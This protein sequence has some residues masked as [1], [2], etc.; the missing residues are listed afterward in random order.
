M[1]KILGRGI[2]LLIGWL[3]ASL[4][5]AQG[6]GLPTEYYSVNDGL[7]DRMV[8]DIAESKDGLL[9]LSTPNGLNRFDGYGFV[10]FDNHPD[11]VNQISDANIR[12][13]LPMAGDR[14][15]IVYRS[16]YAL[17]D[18]FDPLTHQRETV[19]LL[20]KTGVEGIPRTIVS[21]RAG[22][23][24]ALSIADQSTN[25][26][27]YQG[28][29][30]FELLFA[31][32]EQ[33]EETSTNIKMLALAD[34]SFLIHDGEKGTRHF[35]GEGYRLQALQTA[36]FIGYKPAATAA[37]TTI[38]HQDCLG[39]V[40]LAFRGQPGMYHYLP[41]ERELLY[42]EDLPR[43]AYYTRLWEDAKGN[44][45]LG[46]AQRAGELYPLKQLTAIRPDGRQYDFSY[47]LLESQ[48]IVSAHSRDFFK[49]LILGIDTGLKI[50]QNRQSRVQTYLAER[51]IGADQRG[52][53]MRGVVG[54]KQGNVYMAREV[55]HWYR[56]RL[57]SNILDTLSMI[58]A[59][60]GQPLQLACGRGLF[61]DKAGCLWGTSCLDGRT[62]RLHRYNPATDTVQTYTYPYTFS[63]LTLGRDGTIWLTAEPP[64]PKGQLIQFDPRTAR[65]SVFRDQ[66][67]HNPLKDASPRFVLESQEGILWVGSEDGLYRIDPQ[68]RTVDSYIAERGKINGLASNVV[69]AIHED[70]QGRLWLGTTNG[71]NIFDPATESFEHYNQ[72]DGLVSNTVCGFV[73]DE[74]GNY[75]VSTFNGLS[76]FDREDETFHNFFRKEGLSHD[77]F[78]RFSYY[79]DHLGNFYFGGVNGMNVF[80]TE[81]LL[82]DDETPQPILTKFSRYNTGLDSTIVQVAGLNDMEEIVMRPKDSYFNFHF[83]IPAYT[84]PRRNQFKT[85]LSGYDKK[86]TYQSSDAS[87]RLNHLPIGSYEL[88]V[89]GADANGNWS[90]ETLRIPIVVEPAYYQTTWFK[91]LILALISFIVYRIFLFRL[92]QRVK[93][94]RIRTKLSS[95][96]HDEVSGLLAGIAMQTDM[97]QT[98]VKDRESLDRIQQMGEV[99]RKAMSKMSDVIWSI[100]SRKDR[101]EELIIRMREHADEMLSPLDVAYELKV[102]DGID[103]KRKIPVT[104]RQNLYFI[105]KEAVNNIAK[106]SRATKVQIQL[107]NDGSEFHM[108][109]A[110]NG[111]AVTEKASADH[112]PQHEHGK[113]DA[114]APPLHRRRKKKTG[115]GLSNLRMRAARIDAEIDIRT[116]GEGYTVAL[117][118]RRFA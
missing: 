77:E 81:D 76:Y 21:N 32:P 105:F 47:L 112:V 109:I 42:A 22:E 74:Q 114:S 59:A 41:K 67:G 4:L 29:G 31:I 66:E 101:V 6:S 52:A 36:D 62:G 94:E 55:D 16:S 98:T 96:L 9:W 35:S 99:S 89:K 13:L 24:F 57:D 45:L 102:D 54:D 2:I 64:T 40:W 100:D 118:R 23:I 60:T 27:R 50:V 10:V 20:P 68:E 56:L 93:M 25:V 107:E 78:N 87:L 33:H 84:S 49:N 30:Q 85:K 95:D 65:F 46:N 72:Q 34:G 26:Y 58:D 73:P 18:I 115:Q 15:A 104:L 97:L 17:F 48:F 53:V 103:L 71:F 70:A 38:L 7:S 69:Y 110:D 51:D 86:W 91:G 37:A 83:T 5:F 28:E 12:K 90:T 108:S 44:L 116:G 92:K 19:P 106:H 63:S 14:L 75:W 3:N 113:P 11:N 82:L 80:K 88:L 8:T 117:R 79:R 111:A 43:W 61:L 39:K 1:N